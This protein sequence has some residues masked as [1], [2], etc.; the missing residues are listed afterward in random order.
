MGVVSEG[1]LNRISNLIQRSQNFYLNKYI[2]YFLFQLFIEIPPNSTSRNSRIMKQFQIS[3][4]NIVYLLLEKQKYQQNEINLTK[5][6]NKSSNVE[7]D[8]I[9]FSSN[10]YDLLTTIDIINALVDKTKQIPFLIKSNLAFE[11][12][13]KFTQDEIE[14]LNN[15]FD[16][17][18][19][20]QLIRFM[21][22]HPLIDTSIIELINS[23]P[24]ESAPNLIYYKIYPS[25][26]HIPAICIKT[27]AKLIYL[28]NLFIKNLI[29]ISDFNLLAGQTIEVEATTGIPTVNFDTVTASD[30]KSSTYTM[31]NQAYEQLHENA[32]LIFRMQSD[33]L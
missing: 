6:L 26:V 15:H 13:V 27:R 3:L 32:H 20:Q 5:F 12:K 33:R 24:S 19:D 7:F 1:Y 31:F 4:M 22:N 29:S 10:F 14:H 8:L 28:F 9:Q 2:R 30:S 16:T 23:L 25:L 11:D 18:A 21:N 17:I